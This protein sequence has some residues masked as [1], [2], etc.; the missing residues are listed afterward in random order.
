M[1][2]KIPYTLT[3]LITLSIYA[4]SGVLYG[5]A[6]TVWMV[7]LSRGLMGCGAALACLT[8]F[9]YIGEMGTRMDEIRS[10]QGKRPMKCA[11][12]VAYS[13]TYNITFILAFGMYLAS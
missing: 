7:I 8:E 12:Y 10:R 2:E 9:G 1:A 5:M 11:L 13:F 4:V 6:N 3:I